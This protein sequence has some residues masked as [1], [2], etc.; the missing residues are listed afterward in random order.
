MK[1]SIIFNTRLTMLLLL[2]L[3]C[4]IVAGV[5]GEGL[6]DQ[7]KSGKNSESVVDDSLLN[8]LG[9]SAGD[10]QYLTPQARDVSDKYKNVQMTQ[11]AAQSASGNYTEE[12]MEKITTAD[13]KPFEGGTEIDYVITPDNRV[14]GKVNFIF[15]E[16]GWKVKVHG[17][18][19][20]FLTPDTGKLVLKSDD[21]FVKYSGKQYP[22]TMDVNAQYDGS[23]FVGT[24]E[25]SI[26]G[27]TGTLGFQSNPA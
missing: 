25:L 15:M 3:A 12:S 10:Q 27:T 1:L 4:T 17:T 13:G 19:S 22:L 26:G 14:S 16:Q 2:F 8:S 18:V 21:T 5:S 9:I 23:G 7:V 11:K 6:T 24:K 20:G